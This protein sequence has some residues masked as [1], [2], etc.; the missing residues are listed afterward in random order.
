[1]SKPTLDFIHKYIPPGNPA[2]KLTIL[3]LHGTG[4][5]ESDLLPLGKMLAPSAGILSPRGKVLENGMPRF[6]RRFA[7]GVLDLED[8]KV[9]A[10]ELAQF[11][12]SASEEY[13]FDKNRI[14]A[15][16]YSNG[17]NIA[18]ALLL[19]APGLC[20]GGLLL[21]AMKTLDPHPRPNLSGTKALI[22]EGRHDPTMPPGSGEDLADI[23]KQ[24][25]AQVLVHWLDTGHQLTSEDIVV[26]Q[27]WLAQ[28][29]TD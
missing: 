15:V 26:G 3:L 24:S 23:L 9:R 6:F 14:V 7:E 18:N 17:A 21:R 16:G 4:G 28:N 27:E 19:E 13:G 10:N 11:I 1:M 22:C 29:F 8:L 5:D 20:A 2:S 12:T 25:G